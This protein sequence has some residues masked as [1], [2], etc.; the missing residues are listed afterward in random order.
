MFLK[1]CDFTQCCSMLVL[2]SWVP[3]L[4]TRTATL[5]AQTQNNRIL[6][7]SP[8]TSARVV[9][10]NCS[11][12]MIP[13]PTW[14]LS[15]KAPSYRRR[16]QRPIKTFTDRYAELLTFVI[17]DRFALTFYGSQV[18]QEQAKQRKAVQVTKKTKNM[19]KFSSVTVSTVSDDEDELE[20]V[21]RCFVCS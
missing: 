15:S 8:G 14:R 4:P 16:S 19:G 3:T 12:S 5:W 21:R 18:A 10:C 2:Y 9:I 7:H 1:I 6:L 17:S 11:T 20:E 13:L